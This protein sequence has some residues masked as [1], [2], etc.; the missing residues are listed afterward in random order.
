MTTLCIILGIIT[1]I[2][3]ISLFIFINDI[4]EI[5]KQID[6]KNKTKSHFDISIQSH[7]HPIKELQSKINIL[8]E[9]ISNI[10]IIAL[11]KEK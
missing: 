4:K 11:K 7:T 1:V 8:Y 3:L 5:T 9:N 2:S 10:E 6:Y